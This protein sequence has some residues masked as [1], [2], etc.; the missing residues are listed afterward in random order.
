MNIN[1]PKGGYRPTVDLTNP[2]PPQDSG[3]ANI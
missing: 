1:Q 3:T 2:N